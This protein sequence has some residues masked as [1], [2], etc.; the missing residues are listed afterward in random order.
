M[1]LFTFK[2]KFFKH[3]ID[4]FLISYRIETYKIE[5]RKKLKYFF[6]QR[7][8]FWHQVTVIEQKCQRLAITLTLLSVS[9]SGSGRHFDLWKKRRSKI[10]KRPASLKR[11]QRNEAVRRFFIII[12]FFQHVDCLYSI[13]NLFVPQNPKC[14]INEYVS[15]ENCLE[16]RRHRTLIQL[17]TQHIIIGGFCLHLQ[18][19]FLSRLN[20]FAYLARQRLLCGVSGLRKEQ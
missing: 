6:M 3:S 1:L 2:L 20:Q 5:I 15:V 17:T 4:V 18:R 7:F 14:I 9:E 11:V 13:C 16:G 12:A 8:F 19:I 10:A